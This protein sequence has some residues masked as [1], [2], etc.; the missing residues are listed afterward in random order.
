MQTENP[1]IRSIAPWFGSNRTLAKNVGEQLRG[2]KWVGV[3]FAGGMSELLHITAS[4]IVVNDLHRDVINLACVL[5]HEI[6]KSWLVKQAQGMPFHPDILEQAQ[7]VC[8]VEP[9]PFEHP[10]CLRALWY[11]VACWMGRSAKA[12]TDA[13]F[14]GGLPIRWSA[15]GGDSN[16]RYRSAIES[17]EAWGEIMQRCN[18]STLDV[19]DFLAKVK[20]E[21][22]HG[23]YLDPPFPDAGDLYKH[24]F[25]EAQH[26]QLSERLTEFQ[27]VRIVCRFYDHPLIREIYSQDDWDWKFATGRKQSNETAEE[28]LIIKGGAAC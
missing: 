26:R 11:F 27:H 13:E 2:C 15:S 18:F 4:T 6:G 5:Q 17:L 20:D 24:K 14:S 9:P 22:K 23:L 7:D 19:F 10:D 3:P 25:T 21:P 28:V 8:R 12:G 16:T 1:K